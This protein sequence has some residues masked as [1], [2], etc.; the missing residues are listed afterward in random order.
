MEGCRRFDAHEHVLQVLLSLDQVVR[1]RTPAP[2][3]VARSLVPSERGV[4]RIA[5]PDGIG[6][7]GIYATPAVELG[8]NELRVEPGLESL[9]IGLSRRQQ[10]GTHLVDPYCP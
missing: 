7:V 8:P 5:R 10:R 2:R 9:G 4:E 6:R 3:P 1:A